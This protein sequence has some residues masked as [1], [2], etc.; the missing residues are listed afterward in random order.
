M[1]HNTNATTVQSN[2]MLYIL[3]INVLRSTLFEQTIQFCLSL[4]NVALHLKFKLHRFG[5]NPDF[6][7]G[8]SSRININILTCK[9]MWCSNGFPSNF[10]FSQR[11][12]SKTYYWNATIKLVIKRKNNTQQKM[13]QHQNHSSIL[14][15]VVFKICSSY[16]WI[17]EEH[18]LNIRMRI[19]LYSNIFLIENEIIFPTYRLVYSNVWRLNIPVETVKEIALSYPKIHR[20]LLMWSFMT[21]LSISLIFSYF[22]WFFNHTISFSNSYEMISHK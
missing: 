7:L 13:E 6:H 21:H 15:P 5:N 17:Y 18:H 14:Q 22:L 11:H 1:N 16:T 4:P 2:T 20:Y 10:Q 9:L 8:I 12:S 3:Y 19:N